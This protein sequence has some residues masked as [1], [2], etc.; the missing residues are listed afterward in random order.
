[1]KTETNLE[2]NLYYLSQNVSYLERKIERLNNVLEKILESI[3]IM[4]CE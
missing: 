3:L 1:M 2:R 4:E